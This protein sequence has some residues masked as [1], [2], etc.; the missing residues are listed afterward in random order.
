VLFFL[1]YSLSF[2]LSSTAQPGTIVS[3]NH[4]KKTLEFFNNFRW[5]TRKAIERDINVVFC[6]TLL[7]I[8]MQ[9]D[10]V[11]FNPPPRGWFG[12]SSNSETVGA[13]KGEKMEVSG[14]KYITKHRTDTTKQKD[15]PRTPRDEAPAVSFEEYFE[16]ELAK[17]IGK[18]KGLLY[19]SEKYREKVREFKGNVWFS[20]EFPLS[21]EEVMPVIELLTPTGKHFQKLKQ[22]V[23][24]KMPP[25]AGFPVKIEIPVFPTIVGTVSFLHFEEKNDFEPNFFN[26]PMDYVIVV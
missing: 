22:F 6:R 21:I 19:A 12:S 24:L 3:I 18:G 26:V 16:G 14:F 11:V 2:F 4:D 15:Q 9:M 13:W 1:L 10:G 7:K 5:K 23:E 8:D 17:D 20:K 25:E